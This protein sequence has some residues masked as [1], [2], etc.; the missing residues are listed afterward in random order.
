M[1]KYTLLLL[2]LVLVITAGCTNND[3]VDD[4]NMTINESNN[5]D[6]FA[7]CEDYGGI[8]VTQYGECAYVNE[9]ACDDMGGVYEPCA[10]ACRNL[11]EYPDVECTM[12]CIPLCI[13]GEQ[14]WI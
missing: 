14:N 3:M 8:S 13:M 6:F 11:P 10:S 2:A 5:S 4:E 1:K 7:L 9:N 12:E